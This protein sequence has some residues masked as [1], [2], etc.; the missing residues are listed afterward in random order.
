MYAGWYKEESEWLAQLQVRVE[1]RT[2]CDDEHDAG[3]RRSWDWWFL[4][5]PPH[6]A[7]TQWR[8]ESLRLVMKRARTVHMPPYVEAYS[9]S[10]SCYEWYC[11]APWQLYPADPLFRSLQRQQF[12]LEH[13]GLALTTKVV[14][15][16]DRAEA[17][18]IEQSSVRE[19][20]QL[21]ARTLEHLLPDCLQQMIWNFL[22]SE[23]L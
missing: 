4:V 19:H 22:V 20:T 9:R 11:C 2:R 7:L 6:D 17:V 21:L 12:V 15:D 23:R 18:F 5:D 14:L 1:L 3:R 8:L 10:P 16:L 13:S